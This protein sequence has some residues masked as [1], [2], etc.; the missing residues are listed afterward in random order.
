MNKF[1]SSFGTRLSTYA[2]RWIRY[3]VQTAVQ[4]FHLVHVPRERLRILKEDADHSEIGSSVVGAVKNA[5]GKIE[6]LGAPVDS[7]GDGSCRSELIEDNRYS[8]E[9]DYECKELKEIFEKAFTVLKDSEVLTLKWISGWDGCEVLSYSQI[10]DCFGVS[11]AR[12]YEIARSACRKL[13]EPEG[14]SFFEGYVA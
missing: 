10:G 5:A 12:A 1:D 3:G 4:N 11:R 7:S 6:S 2:V 13:N 9:R 8:A 14:R